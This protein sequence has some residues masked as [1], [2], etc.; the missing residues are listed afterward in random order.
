MPDDLKAEHKA[1]VAAMRDKDAFEHT[2]YG[3]YA[4]E[5]HRMAFYRIGCRVPR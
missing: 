4:H 5:H 1:A 3:W 2:P